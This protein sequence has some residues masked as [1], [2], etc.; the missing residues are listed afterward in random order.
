MSP[1]SEMLVRALLAPP[2]SAELYWRRWRRETNLDRMSEDCVRL[3][4]MVVARRPS[5]ISDDPAGNMMRG[6]AKR[7]WTQ[8]QVRLRSAA[9]VVDALRQAGIQEPAISGPGAWALL[10][11]QE[12]SFRPLSFLELLVSRQQVIPAADTLAKLGWTLAPGQILP[13]PEV[14]DWTDAVWFRNPAGDGLKLAWRI[15]PAPPER[16]PEWENIGPFETIHFQGAV[17]SMPSRE[18]MLA[19]ALAGNRAGDLLDW[20]C[21][22]AVLLAATSLDWTRV[23][24]WIQFSLMAR[25]RLIQ[26]VRQSGAVVPPAL[27]RRP[28]RLWFQWDLVRA[29]YHQHAALRGD[30]A[31]VSGLFGYLCERWQT[32]AWRTPLAALFYLVRYTLTPS[33]ISASGKRKSAE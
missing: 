10:H 18:V 23:S 14:F 33:G 25:V 4:P 7:A 20:R 3:L 9:F 24:K 8:N 11:Q 31:S 27:L 16:T 21:D 19:C 22:V 28:P 15:L 6:L 29:D 1:D 30:S 26:F 17:L 32:P 2:D 12:R 13:Q 5:W